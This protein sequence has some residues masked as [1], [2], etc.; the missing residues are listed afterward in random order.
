MHHPEF[1]LLF[2]DNY[3]MLPTANYIPII[4]CRGTILFSVTVYLT[5]TCF[6]AGFVKLA[7]L[8]LTWFRAY[9]LR[10]NLP[11]STWPT[12]S[13]RAVLKNWKH[14]QSPPT[15]FHGGNAVLKSDSDSMNIGIY[16]RRYKDLNSLF[17][18][19]VACQG[20]RPVEAVD[21]AFTDCAIHN[22]R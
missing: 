22:L 21:I 14:V 5:L 1:S 15:T 6:M 11:H 8:Y 20:L 10:N 19:A 18:V 9:R 3:L 4:D 13:P 16:S 2:T 17:C 12:W 7:C